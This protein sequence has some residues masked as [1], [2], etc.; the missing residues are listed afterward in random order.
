M[1]AVSFS[2]TSVSIYQTTWRKSQKIAIFIFVAVRPK[3]S[4]GNEYSDYI[5]DGEF[6]DYMEDDGGSE[7]L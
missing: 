7:L 4:L 3:D 2:E 5:I 6:L 1:E